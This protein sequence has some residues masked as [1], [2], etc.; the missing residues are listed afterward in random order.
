[1]LRLSGPRLTGALVGGLVS[2]LVLG[3]AF[4]VWIGR[5]LSGEPA[6]AAAADGHSSSAP[7]HPA[8]TATNLTVQLAPQVRGQRGAA[9]V[10][11]ALQRYFD[12]IN[13]H[14]YQA[15]A[16][17]VTDGLATEQSG[18]QWRS[19]YSSTTDS[20]I[21]VDSVLTDPLRA[22]V[23]FTSEQDLSLAPQD[24]RST[25]IRWQVTYPIGA[26]HGQLLVDRTVPG[27]VTKTG[28]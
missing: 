19:A 28:C 8:A 14:D 20:G 17:S 15:W 12:A 13:Q 10:Q 6:A 24:L 2:V 27:S 9:A 21:W 1:M 3:G 22:T 7:S 11:T 5:H 18:E 16:Q 23:R 26:F 25:C 4:A